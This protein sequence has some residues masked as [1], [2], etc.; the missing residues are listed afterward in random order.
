MKILFISDHIAMDHSG[1][2]HLAYAHYRILKK[3]YGDE[4]IYVIAL[5]Y[6]M[7]IQKEGFRCYKSYNSWL[8][9]LINIAQG[10]VHCFNNKIKREILKCISENEI[11]I[12]FCDNGYYGKVI[13]MIKYKYPGIKI[14][15]NYHGILKNK[16]NQQIR[17]RKYNPLYW[18]QI[19]R[20][21]EGE[22]YS[23]KYSDTNVVMNWRDGDEMHK[24]YGVQ[25][26]YL[27]PAFVEDEAKIEK[28]NK[29]SHRAE[30]LFVGGKFYPNIQGILWFIENVLNCLNGDVHL[31]IVGS[32]LEC[33]R[34]KDCIKGNDRISV[35]G[36]VDSLA[37]WYDKCNLVIG[38]IFY[39]DGMKTKVAEAI[40]HGKLFLGTPEALCGY[41]ELKQY[42]CKNKEDFIYLI[43]NYIEN[44]IH[45]FYPEIREIY[46]KGYSDQMAE[47][48]LSKII[49]GLRGNKDGKI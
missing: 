40:M 45:S 33:L 47:R 26:D 14:V 17:G 10:N 23:V 15:A 3:M 39:G 42:T 9:Q 46:E 44:G 28:K 6:S 48:V 18:P 35:I 19:F 24:A 16:F 11:K 25:Y 12:V 34:E 30:I 31:N 1:A 49:N 7:E 41:S 27:L 8:S 22:K 43:N 20:L 32:G 36:S 2:S 37:Q 21:F 38:P 13:K 29:V 5:T 4:N